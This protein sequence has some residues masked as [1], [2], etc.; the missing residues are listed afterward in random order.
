MRG[1]DI[2][3]YVRAQTIKWWGYLN[4]MGKTKTPRKI[5]EWNPIGKRSKGRPKNR[6]KDDVLNDLKK[7]KV[8]NWI[9]LVKD[10]KAWCELVQKTKNPQRVVVSAA[11]DEE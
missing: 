10:R 6:W 5:T 9:C 8:K 3:K 11:Q 7:L 4:R 2:V 1:E